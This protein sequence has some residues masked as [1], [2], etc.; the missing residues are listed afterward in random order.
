MMEKNYLAVDLGSS[1]GKVVLSTLN[2]NKIL[3]IREVGRFQTPRLLINGHT[4]IELYEMYAQVCQ[5]IRRLPRNIEIESIGVDSWASDFAVVTDNGDMLGLPVFYRDK[6]TNGKIEK[7]EQV[8]SYRELYKLTTQRKIQDATLCQLL[9]VQEENPWQLS[10]GKMM[11]IGDLMMHFFSKKICSEISVASYTQLF[12]MSKKNW[13]NK[14]FDLFKLPKTLQA[15]VVTAGD[16]LGRI[17]DEQAKDLGVNQFSVIAPAVHD[18]SSACAAVPAEEGENWACIS[19]G[20]WYLVSMELEKPADWEKSYQYNLSNTGLAFGKTLLKRN[21]CAMWLLQEC[22]RMWNK[23]GIMVDYPE[24]AALA[25]AAESFTAFVDPDAVC[26]YNPDN[27]VETICEYLIR[28]KQRKVEPDD[29]GSIARILYESIA[30]KCRYSLETLKAATG[31]RV[32]I[33]YVVG[34]VSEVEFLNFMLASAM[35]LEVNSCVKEAAAV[36]N[37]LLQAYGTGDINDSWDLR[38]VVKNSFDM[39]KYVPQETEIWNH[40]YK[41]FL[42]VCGI[43]L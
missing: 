31:R 18:T 11:H 5:I 25:A 17:S 23:Q 41:E 10:A 16:F 3:S 32:D 26:F 38:R 12:D 37:S 42:A 20:S 28:T 2:E 14:A 22:K 36:G 13:S 8:I 15:P 40:H 35:N 7:V 33:L 30:Y 29:V 1:N 39:K 19:T 21:V 43:D 24:I 27:M 4:C 34:G 6:R 9:A